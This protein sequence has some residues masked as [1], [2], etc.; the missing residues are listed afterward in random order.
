MAAPKIQQTILTP[1]LAQQLLSKRHPRQRRP[2][3]QT[4]AIYAHEMRIGRWRPNVPD[5]ILVDPE[6]QMFNG[7]HRCAAV[8]E[9]GVTIEVW[10]VYD[11]D[12]TMFDVIDVGRKRSA[13]QF[14]TEPDATARASS[15]RIMLWYRRRFDVPLNARGISYFDMAELLA[16]ADRAGESL[17]QAM[18]LA[19]LIYEFTNIP[20]SLCAAVMVLAAE[21]GHSWDDLIDFRDGIV[22]MANLAEDD[23]RRALAERMRQKRHRDR[24]RQPMEDWTIL[25]RALNRF[26]LHE[27]ASALVLTQV[28]PRIGES[29]AAFKKRRN[30][31]VWA[32]DNENR[33]RGARERR[34]AG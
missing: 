8:V 32:R 34:A 15:A 11:A 29:E 30:A 18:P 20:A 4:V 12:P 1:E 13:F 19:R 5:P 31:V 33:G 9:S 25:V 28:W 26:L 7:A 10:I 22:S 14:I 6:G 3:P 27:P 17:S 2:S 16:E 24:R 21:D 23:P